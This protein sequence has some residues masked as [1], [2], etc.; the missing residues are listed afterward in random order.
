MGNTISVKR[1]NFEDMQ[2]ACSNH[3]NYLIINTL[4]IN[5]QSCL[6]KNTI[7]PLKEVDLLNTYL[8]KD[9]DINIII[10][11]L[12][13]SDENVYKKYE[14]LAK[15]GFYNIYI[16]AGGLFEWLLLQDIYGE[17]DFP[18]TKK[19]LDLLKFKGCRTFDIRMIEN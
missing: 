13:A 12:N 17:D 6:I 10:Y 4:D 19:E 15:L 2:I 18:T 5:N 7:L 8:T 14:Q 9:K 1:I 16:Y 3:N 11:G